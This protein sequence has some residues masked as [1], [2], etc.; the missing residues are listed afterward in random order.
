MGFAAA[1]TAGLTAASGVVS[2]LGQS[3]ARKAQADQAKYAAT[4]QTRQAD[5]QARRNKQN[6]RRS[7]DQR[8]EY[9][10]AVRTRM[11]QSGLQMRG[12][13]LAVLGEITSRADESIYD[14][15]EDMAQQV[16]LLRER[17]SMTAWEGEQQ[18][19]ARGPELFGNLLQAGARTA[20]SYYR[21]RQFY[22]NAGLVGLRGAGR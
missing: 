16:G 22:G 4:L 1:L 6:L 15:T 2:A 17:A 8:R 7:L 12:T 18:A 3:A 20:G 9:L 14:L 21:G 13:P 5:E 10:A 19:R 11:A